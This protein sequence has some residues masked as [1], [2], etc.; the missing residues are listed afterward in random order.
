MSR[1]SRLT[2]WPRP[3]LSRGRVL[4]VALALQ[5]VLSILPAAGFELVAPVTEQEVSLVV[6][7]GQLGDMRLRRRLGVERRELSRDLRIPDCLEQFPRVLG[8]PRSQEV[9]THSAGVP[10]NPDAARSAMSRRQNRVGHS[11]A[12]MAP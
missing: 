2:W 8:V 4:A 12:S 9:G 1:P 7:T 10:I 6:G 11:S 3:S 5:P